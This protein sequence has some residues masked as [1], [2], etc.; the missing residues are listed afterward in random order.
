MTLL[1]LPLHKNIQQYIDA[2]AEL[3]ERNANNNM[4]ARA[5]AIESQLDKDKTTLQAILNKVFGG[6][7]I[8]SDGSIT[9]GDTVGKI[10][11]ADLNIF[12]GTATPTNTTYSNALR[13]RNITT[14]DIK[15]LK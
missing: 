10:P 3:A 2:K 9:W 13:T 12:A 6:G 15:T 8:N 5:D 4:D 14:N 7:T 1:L 11:V